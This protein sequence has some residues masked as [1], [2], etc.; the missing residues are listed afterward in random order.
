VKGAL[1]GVRVA[2]FSWLWAGAYA[3]ELLAFLGAEVIKIESRKRP[4]R[5]RRI[6]LTTGQ[7]FSGLDESPVFNHLNLNK[8]DVSIDLKNPRGVELARKIVGISDVVMQNMRPGAM[9]KMGLS[10]EELRKVKPDI[11]YLSSSACGATGPE[12]SYGGYAPNFAAL[13]GIV[14]ITGYPDSPPPYMAGEIDL[15]SATT[16]TFAI[17]A[18]LIHRIE[19]GEGQYIDLSSSETV[20]VLIGEVL[21]DYTMNGRVQG[22]RGNADSIMAPHNCYRSR[23]EDKWVSIA[24]ATDEEWDKFCDVLGNP[25]WTKDERFADAYSRWKNQEELDRL[26]EEWT[27]ALTPQEVEEKLQRNGI[28]A[29]PSFN[30]EELYFSPH[31]EERNFWVKV[32]HPVIGEQTVVAPPWKLSET[33]AEITRPSPLMGEHNQHVFGDLLG[34]SE[35]EIQDLVREK[36]IY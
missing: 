22:P 14:Y 19:T 24:I 3:T 4:D 10:Y 13:G 8:L 27:Q 9:D 7:V 36:V 18:A 30:S 11:I 15:L 2:D 20:S 26:I 28:A 23:G 33:P 6:S 29:I 16:S 25:P 5:A 32:K 21:M 34:M 12:R 17:L 35:S 1:E 31:L